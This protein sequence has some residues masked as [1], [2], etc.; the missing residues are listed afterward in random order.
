MMPLRKV[1]ICIKKVKA[2]WSKLFC[3]WYRINN[4]SVC[5]SGVDTLLIWISSSNIH[6][7]LEFKVFNVAKRIEH[8][9]KTLG[10]ADK[11][12]WLCNSLS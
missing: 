7:S 2:A 10:G 8:A 11:W 6:R 4:Y 1:C 5:S 9:I 3:T 12:L